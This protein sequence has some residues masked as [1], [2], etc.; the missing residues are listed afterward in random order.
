MR[1]VDLH[2]DISGKGEDKAEVRKHDKRLMDIAK[3]TFIS[4]APRQAP[5]L[6][7]APAGR[8]AQ[9]TSEIQPPQPKTKGG[10]SKSFKFTFKEDKGS[11][12]VRIKRDKEGKLKYNYG[13]YDREEMPEISINTEALTEEGKDKYTEF[14]KI[15]KA[16]EKGNDER[17]TSKD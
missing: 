11:Y 17:N 2:E 14:K 5:A 13:Y 1:L 9:Q 3:K 8:P 16:M 4:S 15:M 12:Q 7:S 10:K 6:P